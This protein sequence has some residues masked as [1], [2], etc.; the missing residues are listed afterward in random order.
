MSINKKALELLE[1]LPLRADDAWYVL[2]VYLGVKS[3]AW[4]QI[5]SDAWRDGDEPKRID[6]STRRTM[7]ESLKALGL[8]YFIEERDT[9]AGLWQPDDGRKRLNQ[10]ADIYIA[11]EQATL[12]DMILA[13]KNDDSKL[14]GLSLGYPK[15]AVEAF[16]TD[17]K[18][19]VSDLE[20]KIQM[21]EAGQL[22][23]FALSKDHW[24]D[25][26]AIVETWV[27]ALKDHSQ[28]MWNQLRRFAPVVDDQFIKL[29]IKSIQ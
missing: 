3:G 9:T 1:D 28:I 23:Y 26:L 17:N 19:F 20:P 8:F 27:S 18:I 29:A 25:E 2:L 14:L 24:E 6:A 5:K 21:S 11:K 12:D 15:T 13:R 16:E 7:E 22:T 10:I 4:A